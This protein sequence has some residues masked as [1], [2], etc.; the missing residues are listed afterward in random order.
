MISVIWWLIDRLRE[1]ST[2]AALAA[3]GVL[4]LVGLDPQSDLWRAIVSVGTAVAGL[5]GVILRERRT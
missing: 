2:W 3:S 5:I 1:P 4:A